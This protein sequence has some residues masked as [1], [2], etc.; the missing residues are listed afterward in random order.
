VRLDDETASITISPEHRQQGASFDRFGL[1][2]VQVGGHFVD[3]C[4]R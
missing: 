2:N 4:A 1:F 3:I